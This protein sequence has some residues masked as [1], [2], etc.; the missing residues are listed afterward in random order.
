MAL[1]WSIWRWDEAYGAGLGLK[2]CPRRMG[3]LCVEAHLAVGIHASRVNHL[4][5]LIGLNCAEAT[6]PIV[7]RKRSD[8]HR[9]HG[10]L[11]ARS[12]QQSVVLRAC[13]SLQPMVR[14]CE[15]SAYAG[16]RARC[17]WAVS[18]WKVVE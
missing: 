16:V 12:N 11:L 4:L 18:W 10:D 6:A 14:W 7:E 1:G 3:V 17:C 13:N 5:V 15:G 8:L 9:R 2:S